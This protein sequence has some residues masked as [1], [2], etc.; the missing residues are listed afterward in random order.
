MSGDLRSAKLLQRL[1]IAWNLIEVIVTVGLGVAAGSLALVAFGLDSLVE[2]F[3]SMVVLWHL[4]GTDGS[5]TRDSTARRLVALA[6]VLLAVYLMIAGVRALVVASE[7][8][9]SPFGIAYLGVTALVMFTLASM[10][11]RIGLRLD[12]Q[13]FLAEARL[14]M[15]DG[16]LASAIVSA[17]ALN[18]LFGWWWADAVAALVIS[19]VALREA[20]E[21]AGSGVER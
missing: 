12:N 10:K 15:L 8:D 14:T 19:L 18:T 20:V 6:F 9:S 13:P 5:G 11:K 7:P 4:A 16:A 3:A 17:L 2:V 21:L 1:T